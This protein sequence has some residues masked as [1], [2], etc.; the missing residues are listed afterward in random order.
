MKLFLFGCSL[1]FAQLTY[2][3]VF[4]NDASNNSIPESRA[5]GCNPP[6]ASTFLE[7]NNVKALIHT[8]GNLWQI[9][10]QNFCHY[11]VPKGSGIM[12]LFTS[13]LWLGGVDVNGQ[14]KLAALRYRNG[15]DYWNGPLTTTGE[16]EIT[17]QICNEYDQHFKKRFNNLMAGTM[18]V[19]TTK[20]TEPQ[21]KLIIFLNIKFQVQFLNGQHME[22]SP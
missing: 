22:M 16:A 2:G 21:H 10:G 14:L 7:L 8:A 1:F 5:A 19:F 11:E 3:Q 18:L 13:S 4:L 20:Q 9:P 15:Q 17:S 6:N 12:A